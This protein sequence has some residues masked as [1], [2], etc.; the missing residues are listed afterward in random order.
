MKNFSTRCSR[1]WSALLVGVWALAATTAGAQ[2]TQLS[3]YSFTSGAG[4]IY[5]VTSGYTT[6]LGANTDDGL[7][8]TTDLGFNFTLG[9]TTY[10]NF[11]ANSNGYM[12]LGTAA[13]GTGC[14]G[15]T[16]T[17]LPSNERPAIAVFSEDM[18]NG[19]DGYVAY[20]M[21]GSAPNRVG[22]IHWKTRQYPGSGQATHTA[23]QVRLYEGSNRIELFYGPT[24]LTSSNPGGIG[25]IISSSNYASVNS[26]NVSYTSA[27]TSTFPSNGT[28]Y[29]F[30]PCQANVMVEE[31]IQ[32]GG[33][34]GMEDG[35]SLLV[36]YQVMR[37]SAG[38]IRPF[39]L[40]NGNQILSAC[41]V[42]NYQFTISG[43][44]AG[45]YSISPT[46]GTLGKGGSVTPTITFRPGALGLREAILR[47]TDDAGLAIEYRLHGTGITRIGWDGN[48]AQGGTA[49]VLDGDTLINGLHV[50]F[51]SIG[52]FR[53]LILT[54]INN[55]PLET[56][57]AQ[58]TYTLDDPIGNYSISPATT[59]ITGGQQSIPV[60]TF[61]A[62]GIVGIQEATLTV[63]ADG[64]VRRYLLRAYNAAPGGR[65]IADIEGEITSSNALFIDRHGCVGEDVVALRVTAENTGAGPFIVRGA[66]FYRT[67]TMIMQGA[68]PYPLLRDQ[69]GSFVLSQDYFLTLN[70]A[71][72]PR[73]DNPRFDSLVVPEGGSRTFYIN[74]IANRPGKRFASVVIRTNAFNFG[75]PNL[76]GIPTRGILR[77]TVY[78]RGVGSSIE[79]SKAVDFGPTEVRETKQMTAMIRNSGDCDLRIR[80]S[81]LRLASGDVSEFEIV[82]AL[83]NTP[84]SGDSYLMAPGMEDS[85]VVRFTP[86]TYGSRRATI[87]MVT[88]DSTHGDG[89]VTDVGI[90]YLDLF[91]VGKTGLE[92]RGVQLPPAVI[93]G[94]SSF[95]A[96]HVEN[97]SGGN[98][99]IQSITI[100][101]PTGEIIEDAVRPWPARPMTIRPAES[102]KLWVELR[103]DATEGTGDRTSEM[104]I[105][106]GGGD[107]IR[108]PITGY[109]G[110]RTLV[111]TPPALFTNVQIQSG[112]VMR[113]LLVVSNTGSLP[114]RVNSPVL[115]SNNPGD[116]EMKSLPR[117]VLEPGQTEFIE[118][119][120]TP[121]IPG[122]SGG[123]ITFSSNAT[124]GDQ[125][126]TLGGEGMTIGGPVDPVGSGIRVAGEQ[127]TATQ[128]SAVSTGLSLSTIVPNPVRGTA[129]IGWDLAVAGPIE[130][131]LYDASGRLVATLMEGEA[132]AGQGSATLD[133]AGL[134]SGAYHVVLRQ[135]DE[136][137]SYVITVVK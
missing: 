76:D 126:V 73:R 36:G 95:G 24:Q 116:Y 1:L 56:P 48:E 4:S 105:T 137:V 113:G 127:N 68:P 31:D 28:L 21:F 17:S 88:N 61:N 70:P 81:D 43:A 18:H 41:D 57:P 29:S 100:E 40:R 130:L 30:T 119:Y 101:G 47:V 104:V 11:E 83:V 14:C 94:E 80:K 5:D 60:I 111:V 112:D 74:M 19:S 23:M 8:A 32:N 26:G 79:F 97:T 106:L 33:A 16:L 90:A 103:P 62:Q 96:V 98:A 109:V 82:S 6:L 49:N 10:S 51:G 22:V 34:A 38:Q 89:L 129:T 54:D 37:G 128:K 110:S 87:R 132:D 44:N 69:I 102:Y 64:D 39:T 108:V 59:S 122:V 124:N 45:D 46:N 115:V 84:L 50:E 15:Y 78:G 114:V 85:I 135:G 58:I 75:D 9:G 99:V 52:T 118:V 77:A 134:S 53:P 42:R 67:D 65:L 133:V 131:G 27:S 91:G 25:V 136:R 120:Y 13:G 107:V 20:K 12:V 86:N 3:E 35:D 125:V 7:S 2:V 93:D 117:R 63:N 121:Q 72:S 66:D 92:V 55:D 123:T 71:T